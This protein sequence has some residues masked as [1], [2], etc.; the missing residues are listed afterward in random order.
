MYLYLLHSLLVVA[1][2]PFSALS[3]APLPPSS[4][5]SRSYST[6]LSLLTPHLSS[7]SSRSSRGLLVPNFG[8]Q[9]TKI[10]QQVSECFD[11]MTLP[12]A[13]TDAK[14]RRAMKKRLMEYVDS[15]ISGL[16]ADQLATAY[17]SA[18]S[19]FNKSLLKTHRV[20]RS[21]GSTLSPT[22]DPSSL[23][24]SGCFG[25]QTEMEKL[26]VPELGLGHAGSLQ[27][28]G[29]EAGGLIL[30]DGVTMQTPRS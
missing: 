5:L 10:R 16:H 19:K 18:R 1:L 24:R 29:G 21:D 15:Q 22:A 7:W 30:C 14:E 20:S 11:G 9:A 12:L 17:D 28:V 23:L 25:F 8:A 3:S 4:L 26:D 13:A 27:K 6:S 2:L